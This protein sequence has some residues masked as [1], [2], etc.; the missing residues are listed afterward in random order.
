MVTLQEV[1]DQ[2]IAW[3]DAAT[4]SDIHEILSDLQANI[5]KGHGRFHTGHIFLSFSGMDKADIAGLIRV[6]GDHC[7]SAYDQLRANKS[8][9]P[10]VDGGV[11][12]CF[13]LS[14]SGYKALGD[15]VQIPDGEA[16]QAGMEARGNVLADPPRSVWNAVGWRGVAPDAMFLIADASSETV[17]HQLE[18][19]EGWINGTGAKILVVERGLQQT[20]EFQR[21][22]KEGVEH[23]GYVDGR[24]QPLFLKEDIEA[25]SLTQKLTFARAA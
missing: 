4:N 1:L 17:T 25:E 2:P 14:A 19:A 18:A 9:P 7:T 6:L 15:L 12:R 11:V 5:L 10:Y 8:N 21:G 3:R 23:F 24:S 13:L 16:F 20:R 22:V